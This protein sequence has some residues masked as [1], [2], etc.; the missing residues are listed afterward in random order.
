[1]SDTDRLTIDGYRR[2]VAIIEDHWPTRQS[3]WARA[4]AIYGTFAPYSDRIVIAAARRLVAA[5]G[6]FQPAPADLAEACKAEV[7]RVVAE[8]AAESG[9]PGHPRGC[10]WGIYED[11]PD[12]MSVIGCAICLDEKIVPTGTV[13]GTDQTQPPLPTGTPAPGVG[14]GDPLFG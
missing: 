7:R 8:R 6:R 2:A 12:G 14:S 1:M 5:G 11:R 4:D 3:K 10:V 9:R 13:R